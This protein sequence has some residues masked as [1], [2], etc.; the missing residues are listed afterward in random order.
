MSSNLPPSGPSRDAVNGPSRDAVAMMQYDSAKKSALLAYLLWFFLGYFGAH[1]FY[2]GRIGSG[3]AM[4]VIFLVSFPLAYVL[5]GMLGFLVIFIWWL[6]DALLIPGIV[7][8]HNADLIAR[9]QR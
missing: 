6:V 1:R 3:I 7:A 5:I 9:L 4:L 8:Q 2:L